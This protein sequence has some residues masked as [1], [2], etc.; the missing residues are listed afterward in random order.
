MPAPDSFIE[1]L[2]DM[3]IRLASAGDSS[4][5]ATGCLAVRIAAA[6]RLRALALAMRAD[7]H[8]ALTHLLGGAAF[9][10][11]RPPRGRLRSPAGGSSPCLP[12]RHGRS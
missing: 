4:V 11:C 8:V 12:C 6:H 7:M 2:T 9:G 10:R 3:A 1:L 5:V